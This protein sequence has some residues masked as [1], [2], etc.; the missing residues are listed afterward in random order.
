MK[1]S[2]GHWGDREGNKGITFVFLDSDCWNQSQL[3]RE[4]EICVLP[5][6]SFFYILKT[7]ISYHLFDV[8][9][10]DSIYIFC[11]TQVLIRSLVSYRNLFHQ[12]HHKLW[13]PARTV[14]PDSIQGK[15]F[16]QWI[17]WLGLKTLS[18]FFVDFYQVKK[19]SFWTLKVGGVLLMFCWGKRPS[20]ANLF[21]LREGE[22][23]DFKTDFPEKNMK[24]LL[25]AGR[26]IYK[27][28][29]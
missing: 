14:P 1:S 8:F 19:I 10:W 22:V 7:Y 24:C 26:L 18:F 3:E 28:P 13:V 21:C 2:K 27:D 16:W 5:F 4:R 17:V 25:L 29:G 11:F 12:K 9:F 23:N 6:V 20:G 15:A